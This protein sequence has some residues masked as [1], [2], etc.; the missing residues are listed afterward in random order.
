MPSARLEWTRLS[1]PIR[2]YRHENEDQ[3]RHPPAADNARYCGD[4]R[5][6]R[7]GQRGSGGATHRSRRRRRSL[8]RVERRNHEDEVREPTEVSAADDT[9]EDSRSI[10]EQ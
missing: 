6:D 8:D 10:D 7:G 1:E 2:Q 4:Y 9:G 3:R 5:N